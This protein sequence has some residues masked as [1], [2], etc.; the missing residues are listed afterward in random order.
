MPKGIVHVIKL[1]DWKQLHCRDS[2]LLEI[3]NLLDKAIESSWI[4]DPG[5]RMACESAH[6]DLEEDRF[7]EWDVRRFHILPIIYIRIHHEALHGRPAINKVIAFPLS[8]T[9]FFRTQ[10]PVS[11]DQSTPC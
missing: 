5:G 6:M 10:R 9:S 1:L 3:W 4:F 2:K 11:T 8:W 7:G